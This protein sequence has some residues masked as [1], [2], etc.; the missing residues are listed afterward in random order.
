MWLSLVF[1]LFRFF[2]DE[3]SSLVSFLLTRRA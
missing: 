1:L 2:G 3:P